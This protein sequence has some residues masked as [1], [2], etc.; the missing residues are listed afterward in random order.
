VF[1]LVPGAKFLRAP[2]TIMFMF[3]CSASVLS[4]FFI[5]ALLSERVSSLAK[6]LVKALLALAVVLALLFVIGQGVFFDLWRA[7]FGSAGADKAA[8]FAIA[9]RALRIDAILLVVFAAATLTL[10][11]SAYGRKWGGG[12]WLGVAL[13][14]VLAT[15]L[16]HSLRFI[17]TLE[18]G[19]FQQRDPMIDYVLADKG[20]FRTL[21]MTHSSFYNRNFLPLFDIETAN[22]FYDNR[23]RYFD[24]FAGEGF[25]NLLE[26]AFMSIANVKYVLTTQRVDHPVLNLRRDLGNAFVYENRRF[27]PRAFLVHEAVVA[28]TDSA[29]I[30]VMKQPGFDPARTIVL[31]DGSPTAGDTAVAGERVVLERDDGDRVVLKASVKSPGY[32]FYSGNYLPYWKAYVDGEEASVVRCNVSFR[33]VRIEPGEHVVEMKYQSPYLRYGAFI[34]LVSCGLIGGMIYGGVRISR[35]K[36]R[37]A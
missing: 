27:L 35:G 23:I 33:A 32:L 14:G 7:V 34:C 9:S 13:A 6:K 12:L 5:E 22:G 18:V 11:G 3:S 31:H 25:I 36:R 26:P 4:A 10:I 15:S 24:E 37:H 20:T 2:S 21:P 29:A 17:D 28:S 19:S 8:A 16:P 1:Q 30:D